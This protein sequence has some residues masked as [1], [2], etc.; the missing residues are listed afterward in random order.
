M[1][2]RWSAISGAALVI[3]FLVVTYQEVTPEWKGYQAEFNRMEEQ[4]LRQSFHE[5]ASRVDR[6]EVQNRMMALEAEERRLRQELEGTETQRQYHEALQELGR[7]E[8]RFERL[9][10]ELQRIRADY[11]SLERDY[12][13]APDEKRQ[14]QVRKKLD[15]TRLLVEQATAGRDLAKRQVQSQSVR[16]DAFTDGLKEIERQKEQLV[17]EKEKLAGDIAKIE[18]RSLQIQQVVLEELSIVDRCLTCHPGTARKLFPA[19]PATLRSHPGF[20]LEDHPPARFGCAICHGGQAR[21]T[22]TAAA[23]GNVPHWPTPLVPNSYLGGACGKCHRE[24]EI[25]FEPLLNDG[26]RLFTEAGCVGCHDVEGMRP[27][28]K[29]GPALIRVGDKVNGSWLARWLRNPKDY[30]PNTRMPNFMLSDAEIATLQKFL[31]SLRSPDPP[32][33]IRLPQDEE[34]IARGDKLF[35]ESRCIT[36]HALEGRGG[37]IGP[38]LSRVASK[39]GA[40]WLYEFLRDPKSHFPGTKMPRYRFTDDDRLALVAYIMANLWD[41]DWEP[42][43]GIERVEITEAQRM[44]GHVLV[45]KYGCYGCHDIPGFEKVTKVGTEL[46]GYADKEVARLDFGTYTDIEKTWVEWTKTKLK[47]PRVFRDSLKMPD[48]GLTP[49]EIE[50]LTVFLASLSEENIP[51][52]YRA[53]PR[54]ASSYVPE[55]AFGRLVA[56]M[57]CFVC[58]TIRGRGGALAPDLSYEGSRVQAD[59]LRSFLKN[60]NTIRLHMI[61][62]MPRFNLTDDEVETIVNYMQTVLLKENIA[63]RVFRAGE[64][65]A[66]LVAE[67]RKIYYEKYACQACHQIGL[68][69]GAVGPELTQVS[70][71]LTEGWL[72][73]WLVSSQSLVPNVKEPQYG[74]SE[75]E[76]RAV[77][78]FLLAP[79]SDR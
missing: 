3:L 16:V 55:G 63:E 56:D 19:G 67:G 53:S 45:R 60:P 1:I 18:S 17:A 40:A 23:H 36:C 75:A 43:G 9:Q 25:P 64:I 54:P 47:S 65:T 28:E 6:P 70:K 24:E 27:R 12:I 30:L 29:I 73:A 62:R 71:R 52:G 11:Q 48:F 77:A 10:D 58:H 37:T 7:L 66:A 41:G 78:A 5:L 32:A 38:E 74:M 15:A 39:V 4:K 35:R 13:L 79:R 72:L 69:G 26:R 22:K 51:P 68:E 8:D 76:A 14:A 31:L 20:Y 2:G 33:E 59:W 44:A 49:D 57:N 61:E 50:A 42:P 46:N 21:A 34:L